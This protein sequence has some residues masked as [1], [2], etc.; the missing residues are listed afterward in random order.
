MFA[1]YAAYSVSLLSIYTLA[2]LLGDA[3]QDVL[4]S[5]Y[6]YANVQANFGTPAAVAAGSF[7]SPPRWSCRP[8][9]P[10]WGCQVL[11]SGSADSAL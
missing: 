4:V 2:F 3:D 6:D 8:V 9:A 7:L 1:A 5:A 11:G 10:P